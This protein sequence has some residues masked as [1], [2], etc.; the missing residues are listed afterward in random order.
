[1]KAAGVTIEAEMLT[2]INDATGSL[3]E[4]DPTLAKSPET[5]EA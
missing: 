1:M 3:A 2:K 5:R 4:R